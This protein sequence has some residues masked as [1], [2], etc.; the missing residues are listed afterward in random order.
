MSV[1]A[2]V[3]VA[4]CASFFV[5]LVVMTPASIVTH[6]GKQ[7][8][9]GVQLYKP[10]GSI[11]SGQA[12]SL[13]VQGIVF[14]NVVWKLAPLPILA[15][16]LDLA[17]SARDELHPL[18]GNIVAG[19]D[20]DIRANNIKGILPANMISHIK[21]IS[22]IGLEG[23]LNIN[24]KELRI[25]EQGLKAA[26]GEILL[27]N[28]R[29]TLPLQGNLGNIKLTLS[30]QGNN[31]IIRINDLHAPIGIDGTL[32]LQPNHHF[33]FNARFTPTPSSDAILL[34]LIKNAARQQPDGRL[35]IQYNG[36][37]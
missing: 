15:G 31:I 32:K 7:M 34:S 24:L 6:F 11:W 25:D 29:L 27:S 33:N 23:R 4:G 18:K 10:Q 5:S 37:Y 16:E 17:F 26:T 21:A 22:F 30:N 12:G 13:S 2:A 20:G 14:H 1:R 3:I 9:D 8:M 19:F 28:G 35:Q 36:S